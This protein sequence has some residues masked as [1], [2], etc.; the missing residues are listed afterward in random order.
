MFLSSSIYFCCFWFLLLF[1]YAVCLS[2][3]FAKFASYSC[4]CSWCI[5]ALEVPCFTFV[6]GVFRF[7]VKRG[8]RKPHTPNFLF[9]GFWDHTFMHVIFSFRLL[10]LLRRTETSSLRDQ[11]S[12]GPHT[13][14]QAWRQNAMTW[15]P[16]HGYHT[17][18]GRATSHG[19][20][21]S[22][23]RLATGITHFR[24]D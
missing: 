20:H 1:V 24:G 9:L 4:F 12:A 16:S 2:F 17:S 3:F 14:L 13:K 8:L 22:Q 6:P 15:R 19:Y 7:E 23:G 11:A 21:T 10:K 18:Q 5:V